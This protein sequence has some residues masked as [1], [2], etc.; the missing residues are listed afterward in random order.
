MD[1]NA[2]SPAS[3]DNNFCT[4]D[5]CNLTVGCVNQPTNEGSACTGTDI[6]RTGYTCLSGRCLGSPVTCPAVP[7]NM[8]NGQCYKPACDAS[9]GGC[10]FA[11]DT[12]KAC[13]DSNP[14]TVNDYCY[15]DGVCRG[16]AKNC[17]DQNQV[18]AAVL[19]GYVHGAHHVSMQCTV[20]SCERSTGLCFNV[21]RNG[22]CND[23][24]LCTV[25]DYCSGGQC[26][27]G[28]T[29]LQCP[30]EQCRYLGF[31]QPQSGCLYT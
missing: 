14:C 16:S 3:Q 4:A 30:D 31:C 5:S 21:A 18:C 11:V 15:S 7:A 22:T 27:P 6:C 8:T 20:D 1:T 23:N 26:Q 28:P 24:N 12:N 25:G 2:R 13:D 9:R 29:A 10:Y 17:D 19:P